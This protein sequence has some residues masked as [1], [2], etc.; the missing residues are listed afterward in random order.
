MGRVIVVVPRSEPS[1]FT[2][3]KHVFGNDTVDVILDRR[4]GDRRRET[5]PVMIER[6]RAERRVRMPATDL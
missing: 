4:L 5:Q 2:Y 3:V 6:R 1:R